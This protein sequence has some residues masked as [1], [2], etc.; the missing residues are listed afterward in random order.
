MFFHSAGT[1]QVVRS[2]VC[3]DVVERLRQVMPGVPPATPRF[4]RFK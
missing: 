3:V 2:H 4:S 1:P